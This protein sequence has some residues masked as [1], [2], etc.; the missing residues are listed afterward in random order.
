LSVRNPYFFF[1]ARRFFGDTGGTLFR[2]LARLA[3]RSVTYEIADLEGLRA[4]SAGRQTL[5]YI[6]NRSSIIEQFLVNVFLISRGIRAPSHSFGPRTLIFFTFRDLWRLLVEW[7]KGGPPRRY[8]PKITALYLPVEDQEFFTHDPIWADFMSKIPAKEIA[9]VPVTTLWDKVFREEKEE[10][11][12]LIPFIGTRYLWSTFRELLLL[13]LGRR[14]LTV[15]L[16]VAHTIPKERYTPHLY[17]KFYAI[18]KGEKKNVVGAALRNWFE[19]RNETLLSLQASSELDKKKAARHLDEIATHY[20]P[21]FTEAVS[22]LIG[23]LLSSVFSRILYRVEELDYL[24]RLAAVRN[25]TL[26]FV[27]SHRSYFD[28]LLMFH[29]LYR[30]QVAIPLVVAGDNL[31]FFP[32]GG[33]LRRLG[34]FFIRRRVRDDAAYQEVFRA[35]L[36]TIVESGYHLEFFIE[37]GRTRS[38][39]VRAPRTGVLSMLADIRKKSGRRLYIVPVSIAYEQLREVRQYQT[40]ATATKEPERKGF[41]RKF[42]GL[43]RGSAGPVSVSFG[44]PLYLP[45]G[46]ADDFALEVAYRI[47][48]NGQVGFSGLFAGFFLADNEVFAPALVR[49]MAHLVHLLGKSGRYRLAPALSHPELNVPRVIERLRASGQIVESRRREHAYRLSREARA[50]FAYHRNT[51]AFALAPLFLALLDVPAPVKA[52]VERYLEAVIQGYRTDDRLDDAL[53]PGEAESWVLPLL[54]RFFLPS[55]ELLAQITTL[56]REQPGPFESRSAAAQLIGRLLSRRRALFSTDEVFDA[57]FYLEQ[58]GAIDK[59][60]AFVPETGENVAAETRTIIAALKERGEE[61]TR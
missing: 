34:A 50:E 3:E 28:Y 45:G 40:E 48:R 33:I 11:S 56:L 13:L 47:E 27:P 36:R 24:R 35:Y 55:F 10:R 5:F 57:L 32:L 58:R 44:H 52:A 61:T 53:V 60:F 17:R 38:G 31:D 51:A 7:L 18:L 43:I 25:I 37:G 19:I 30:E 16:G 1:S 29:L 41:L 49:K 54:C 39:K 12:W 20:S 21:Y 2:V 8:A 6:S 15:R 9:A 14:R 42:I 26:V 59:L 23:R 4:L 46:A 22:R